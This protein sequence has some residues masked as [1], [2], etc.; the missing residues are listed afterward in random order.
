MDDFVNFKF[1]KLII[2]N[3]RFALPTAALPG[4]GKSMTLV[5]LLPGRWKHEY[6]AGDFEV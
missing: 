5:R 6:V 1:S 2:W 3:V 4:L